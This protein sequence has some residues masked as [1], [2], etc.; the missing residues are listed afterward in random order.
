MSVQQVFPLSHLPNLL[1]TI[2]VLFIIIRPARIIDV[3][4]ILKDLYLF[5]F[6]L[7]PL[8]ATSTFTLLGNIP[9]IIFLS[10]CPVRNRRL[11]SLFRLLWSDRR[12]GGELAGY[13]FRLCFSGYRSSILL[14]SFCRLKS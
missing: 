6:L 9:F 3:V 12:N 10:S 7:L 13:S 11:R 2:L 1:L 5:L 4:P 8:L 14:W